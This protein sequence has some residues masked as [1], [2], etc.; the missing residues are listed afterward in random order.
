MVKEKFDRSKAYVNIGTIGF[1]RDTLMLCN[2]LAST[3]LPK[4]VLLCKEQVGEV[5]SLD[6]S[7]LENKLMAHLTLDYETSQGLFMGRQPASFSIGMRGG[8]TYFRNFLEEARQK[9]LKKISDE[10][11]T[12]VPTSVYKLIDSF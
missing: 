9:E 7:E 1:P 6:Y 12:R 5:V 2:I 11:E 8:K 4:P 3:R 10:I